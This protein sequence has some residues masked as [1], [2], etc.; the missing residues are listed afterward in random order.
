MRPSLM[1]H[2]TLTRFRFLVWCFISFNNS[3]ALKATIFQRQG[4][5][6]EA[7]SGPSQ[8]AQERVSGEEAA[9]N[10]CSCVWAWCLRQ[11][12]RTALSVKSEEGWH[13]GNQT[14]FAEWRLECIWGGFVTVMEILIPEESGYNGLL[15]ILFISS[16]WQLEKKKT[17]RKKRTA[18]SKYETHYFSIYFAT[19]KI[20]SPP[21]DEHVS[22]RAMTATAPF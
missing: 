16:P 21:R 18:I 12:E 13:P 1:S 5:M 14:L 3:N 20:L 11:R 4:S 19:R 9:L 22:K 10:H 2:C 17:I 7:A 6:N 8:T 15:S